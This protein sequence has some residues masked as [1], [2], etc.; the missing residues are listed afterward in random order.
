[1]LIYYIELPPI[2]IHKNNLIPTLHQPLQ[3]Q[4]LNLIK[5]PLQVVN[6]EPTQPRLRHIV[7]GR[8]PAGMLVLAYVHHEV[9]V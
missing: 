7:F 3:D 4:L 8:G 1:M 9:V 2:S 6:T 5:P